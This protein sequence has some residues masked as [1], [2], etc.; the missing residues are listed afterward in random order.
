MM[1]EAMQGDIHG[2]GL[3]KGASTPIVPPRGLLGTP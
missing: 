2:E 1:A 3:P